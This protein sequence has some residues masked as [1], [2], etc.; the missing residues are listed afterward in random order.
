MPGKGPGSRSGIPCTDHEGNRF[1]SM[2]E[3][4]RH[5]GITA[6]SYKER[7]KKG[8]SQE[9]A[10]TAPK[11]KSQSKPCHDHLGNEYPSST[12]MFRIY[13]INYTIWKY[14]HIVKGWTLEKT[15][16]T[17]VSD[18]DLAGAHECVD[19][20]GNTFPSKKAMCDHWR[21]PRNVFF[22]RQ[23]QG[24][25][26]QQCLAPVTRPR[27]SQANP[28]IDPDGR[29]FMNLDAM[30][31]HWDIS[32]SQYILNIRNGLDLRRA[33]TETTERPDTP[34]DHLGNRYPSINA[35]C[36][37]Y[38]ITKT[39]L[40]ARLELG[41]TLEQILSHPENNSHLIQCT[42][43]LGNRF[44]S[45]KDM[46]DAYGVSHATYKHRLSKGFSLEQSLSGKSLH[47]IPCTD[48]EGRDFPCLAAMLE[49][50]ICQPA[51]W[52]HRTGEL[53]YSTERALT[54]R[55]RGI[56]EL[57]D[58]KIKSVL[59]DGWMLIRTGGQTYVTDMPGLIRAARRSAMI[60]D[61]RSGNLPRG[62]RAKYLGQNWFQVWNTPK[63][64][65]GPGMVLDTDRAYLELC[66]VRYSD[67]KRKD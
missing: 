25:D 39:T 52:H 45:Q 49:Y 50:W 48:H 42:D 35:M 6:A 59:E 12:E 14:R 24:L 61:I 28:I 41:W 5:W 63:T 13:G 19:H 55:P 10:L 11:T 16:T 54:D 43:H 21:V 30:C 22:A 62:M 9:E 18:P 67:T 47:M 40:R 58:V 17:P 53:G 65:Q 20:M 1:K 38:G 66:L 46:L 27:A 15:L 26:L 33:L 8:M 60:Q 64:G 23:R 7:L 57:K 31:A 29:E 34:T 51:T 36:R 2:S 4:C 32:K 44:R 56:S 37:A 3:M